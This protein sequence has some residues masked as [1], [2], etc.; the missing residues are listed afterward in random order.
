MFRYRKGADAGEKPR[1]KRRAQCPSTQPNSPMIWASAAKK[2]RA[3]RS[4]YRDIGTAKDRFVVVRVPSNHAEGIPLRSLGGVPLFCKTRA[5]TPPT[6]PP[7][8]PVAPPHLRNRP[9]R[10]AFRQLCVPARDR[11]LPGLPLRRRGGL[12]REQGR[13]QP[14]QRLLEGIQPRPRCAGRASAATKP[15]PPP[16]RTCST[17]ACPSTALPPSTRTSPAQEAFG[18]RGVT[19]VRRRERLASVQ[20]LQAWNAGGG[21][22]LADSRRTVDASPEAPRPFGTRPTLPFA[23]ERIC[24]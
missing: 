19:C 24:R 21:T 7:A 17:R 9:G 16:T 14:V 12:H 13:E 6:F 10:H 5:T 3:V 8:S 4:A 18:G 11:V 23:N 2:T 1:R 15:A 20:T 22:H